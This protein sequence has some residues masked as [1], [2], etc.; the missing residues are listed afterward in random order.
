[1]YKFGLIQLEARCSLS[2][3]LPAQDQLM[4]ISNMVNSFILASINLYLPDF[5]GRLRCARGI[6]MP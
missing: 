3:V 5:R 4:T 6:R 1:M 2:F